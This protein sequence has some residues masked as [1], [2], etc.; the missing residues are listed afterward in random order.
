MLWT[1]GDDLPP[2][3]VVLETVMDSQISAIFYAGKAALLCQS[4]KKEFYKKFLYEPLPVEVS[5]YLWFTFY[6]ALAYL[7]INYCDNKWNYSH[8]T[9]QHFH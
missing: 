9:L 3:F 4:S 1:I 8:I 7:N 5:K 6:C 2:S